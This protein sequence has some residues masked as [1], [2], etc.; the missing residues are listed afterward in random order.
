MLYVNDDD[1]YYYLFAG[2]SIRSTANTNTNTNTTKRNTQRKLEQGGF[3]IHGFHKYATKML[4]SSFL[5]LSIPAAVS[6]LSSHYK[7]NNNK[8]N[9]TVHGEGNASPAVFVTK[10]LPDNFQV[11]QDLAKM[12]LTK[13]DMY[14]GFFTIDAATDSNTY[15]V[16]SKALN[17]D[18]EAPVLLWLQGGPG[19]SSLFGL[20]TE[21]GPFNIG[22]EMKIEPRAQSWNQDHHMLFLDNPLGTGFSFTSELGRMA[23][24]QTTIGQDLYAALS[25]FFEMFPDLRSNDFFVTGESYA[26][27]YVPSCAFEIHNQ[28]QRVVDQENKINLKGIAIGDGAF[29]PA[30]QFY[31]FGDLLFYIGMADEVE[32]EQ[33]NVYEKEWKQK[34]E[35][36]D[37]VGAF[38][39]FDEMLNGDF[40][41]YP[42]YYANR[43]GMGS[44]YFNFNQGPDGSSLTE[45]YFIDWLGT[46]AG[47]ELM[48]VGE[49]PYNVFNQTVESQLVGDW[50]LGVVDKLTV[51]LEHYRVLIYNGQYDIILGPPLTEQALRNIPW[52]GQ[53]QYLETPKKIWRI[54]FSS[55]PTERTTTRQTTENNMLRLG[56][57]IVDATAAS[58]DA[59]YDTAFDVA[60]YYRTVGDF[61]QLVVRGAGHMVP[62]DQPFRAL[63]MIKRFVRGESFGDN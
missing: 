45:N 39:V 7:N 52:S 4:L 22:K 6:S 46:T 55:S 42:T 25:Q 18:I 5:L 15:F 13:Y 47:R 2:S 44:N 31:N 33:F 9:N 21:I 51:L 56:T 62:G 49:I 27:K 11:A 41:P 24:N 12:E 38:R 1:D 14:S 36:N 63:D 16:F 32:R 43:T 26:G 10:F 29:D 59:L 58:P 30:G 50:M 17:G 48:H 28:N 61:T 34:M 37:Y 57:S 35:A 23:T 3:F 8:N 53:E 60:G 40:Y 20:F 54:P 19:A